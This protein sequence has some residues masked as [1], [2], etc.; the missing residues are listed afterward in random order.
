MDDPVTVGFEVEDDPLGNMHFILNQE[1]LGS[2]H[3]LLSWD[4]Q[5]EEDMDGAAL[6]DAGALYPDFAVMMA[7][8][9]LDN[10]EA[11]TAAADIFVS[12]AGPD[13]T[14]RRPC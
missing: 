1:N 3:A 13:R 8:H 4:C 7:D 10:E 12:C 11:E 9:G 14:C 2:V 5:G 6:A